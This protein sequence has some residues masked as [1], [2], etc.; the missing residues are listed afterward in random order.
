MYLLTYASALAAFPPPAA[1]CEDGLLLL[2][3]TFN[4]QSGQ[5]A[6]A[7]ALPGTT[8]SLHRRF[9]TYD[10]AEGTRTPDPLNAIEMR[11]QL[12]Y[13]PILIVYRALFVSK[14]LAQKGGALVELRGF[15]PLTS[16]VRLMRAPSCA[17]APL[18]R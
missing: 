10:G 6:I 8:F 5:I 7:Y 2:F 9:D 12:R 11:S 4:R 3:N 13:S 14:S 16:S 15:E 1:L 18:A 17:T